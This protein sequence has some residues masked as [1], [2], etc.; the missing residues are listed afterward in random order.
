MEGISV[1]EIRPLLGHVAET[2]S[3]LDT[4]VSRLSLSNPPSAIIRIYRKEHYF[5]N[6]KT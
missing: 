5:L 6:C 1:K 4:Q 3:A 2:N